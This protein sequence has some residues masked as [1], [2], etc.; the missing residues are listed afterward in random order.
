MNMPISATQALDEFPWPR[1]AFDAPALYGWLREEHPVTEVTLPTGKKAWLV[2]RYDDVRAILADPRVSADNRAENFPFFT[3]Q[4]RPSDSDRLFL[5]MDPPEHS[6]LRRLLGKNFVYKRMTA[7]RPRIQELVDDTIDRML[8]LHQPVDFVKEFALPIPSTVLSWILGVRAHDA[9]FFNRASEA[10]VLGV[11]GQPELV[12]NG[13]RATQE[14]RR[15]IDELVTEK[16]SADS[17][18]DDILGQL[19]TAYREGVCGRHD[20]VNSGF[21]LAIAGHDTTASM[22]AAGTVTLL[23]H[24][25]QL[26]Q[27]RADPQLWPQAIEELLRYLTVVH[28]IIQRVA[29]ED[30]EIAGVT[31]PAGAGIIPLNLSANRDDAHFPGAETLDI[32]RNMRDHFAF[33]YGIHQCIGQPLARIELEVIYE[34]LFR[35]L[36]E[37]RLALASDE[38]EF[39][40][41]SPISGV[42]S[43][44]VRW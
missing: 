9:E 5:R 13:V 30:I 34:T 4:A 31:I 32:H 36:P 25:E 19:V 33:G 43:L 6:V 1:E 16:E 20:I 38:I 28:L 35:R 10:I 3:S 14:L 24:P 2:S 12:E 39:K 8:T 41:W 27:L 11:S 42:F 40:R 22:T 26:S 23:Q 29:S 37:L 7:M 17:P 21:L 18:G 15:Y 44:P